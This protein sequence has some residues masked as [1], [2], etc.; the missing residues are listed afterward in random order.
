MRAIN[1]AAAFL[2]TNAKGGCNTG[3]NQ[4]GPYEATP[5]PTRAVSEP[6]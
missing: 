5:V 1:A 2:I 6:S 4:Y 3:S